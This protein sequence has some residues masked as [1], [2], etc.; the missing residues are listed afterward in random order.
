[1]TV[2]RHLAFL[3]VGLAA[4]LTM[5]FNATAEPVTLSVSAGASA[6]AGA[7]PCVIGD[8]SCKNSQTFDYTLIPAG[9]DASMLSSPTYTVDQLRNVVGGDA[10]TIGVDLNQAPGQDD[11]AYQ[12]HSFTMLVNGRIF[13][14]TAAP[15][16]LRP[17]DAG[18]GQADAII[19]GF[20]LAGLSGTDQV[21]FVA[22]YSGDTGGREQFSVNAVTPLGPNVPPNLGGG[23]ID[24]APVPE[25]ASMVLIATG[26]AGAFAARRRKQL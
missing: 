26:L 7:G 4:V 12:L 16:T 11:G 1:M 3:T 21:T 10:F 2:R 8:P 13:L 20:N 15:M 22:N 9:H 17:I 14:N 5:P 18:T 23:A 6:Q 25:P 24:P 19:S